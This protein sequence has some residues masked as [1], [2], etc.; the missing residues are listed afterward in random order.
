MLL[1]IVV[2]MVV[3]PLGNTRAETTYTLTVS[4]SPIIQGCC[5]LLAPQGMQELEGSSV[6]LTAND[7]MQIA[8]DIRWKLDGYQLDG[9][10]IISAS[11]VSLVMFAPHTVIWI[12]HKEVMLTLTSNYG[13]PNLIGGGW[14]RTGS[15][16][17][18][19]AP[20]RFFSGSEQYLFKSW[21]VTLGMGT[22]TDLTSASTTVTLQSDPTIQA[23][24]ILVTSTMTVTYTTTM[25]M[26]SGTATYTTT[27]TG[28][29]AHD[30]ST[31]QLQVKDSTSQPALLYGANVTVVDDA[32]QI[33][34]RGITDTSGLTSQF[35]LRNTQIYTLQIQYQSKTYTT[36]QTFPS[37]AVY[38]VDIS[39][40]A[41]II[42]LSELS[43]Y[44]VYAFG[45]SV[46][47]VAVVVY[48]SQ[49][50]GKESATYEWVK[51]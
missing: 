21:R 17:Q 33:V 44:A 13:S 51:R 32:N 28:I 35:Q 41:P 31:V 11:T 25:T 48:F 42:T 37:S 40:G 49:R 4:S 36:R 19:T 3:L 14:Q 8:S 1:M 12:W 29:L 47:L 16:V 2:V 7:Q 5:N 50:H 30:Q 23:E 46:V 10:P 20:Q 6:T 34:W 26:T 39:T 43:Q 22:I 38:P 9:A 27:S 15:A 45:V 18:I 24:Y